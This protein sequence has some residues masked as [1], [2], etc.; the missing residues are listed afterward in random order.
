MILYTSLYLLSKYRYAIVGC[1]WKESSSHRVVIQHNTPIHICLPLVQPQP[2]QIVNYYRSVSLI[3]S[4]WNY[5]SLAVS[6]RPVM[7]LFTRIVHFLPAPTRF[8]A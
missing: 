4:R 3:G 8:C 6:N 1:Q 7:M 2:S 5:Y